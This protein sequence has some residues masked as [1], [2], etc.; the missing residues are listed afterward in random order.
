MVRFSD[1]PFDGELDVVATLAGRVIQSSIEDLRRRDELT[2]ALRAMMKQGASIDDLSAASGLTPE[3]IK[4]IV[5]SELI[6]DSDI[7][8]LVGVR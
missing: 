2:I 6:L 5:E 1:T 3:D 8:T 4:R 7:D